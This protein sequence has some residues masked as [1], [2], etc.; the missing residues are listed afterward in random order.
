RFGGGSA[1]LLA[2]PVLAAA[3]GIGSFLFHTY[4]E[5]WAGIADVAP[6]AVFMLTGVYIVFRRLFEAP[7][8][9]SWLATAGFVG[10]MIALPAA[11]R[12]LGLGLGAGAGYAP[13][14]L[15]LLGAGGVLA[16]Q[17]RPGGRD[18]FAAGAVFTASLTLR[19]LDLP[20]CDATA[21]GAGEP[22]GLHFLW[23]ILNAVTLF[24]V[25][26]ASLGPALAGRAGGGGAPGAAAA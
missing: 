20:L 19:T 3:I 22:I 15:T 23:H 25:I 16:L 5:R 21:I 18:L 1:L 7:I 8:W 24:L 12:A 10:L 2:L 11:S 9:A 4:A 14:L 17:G 13:A 26:R 6:I